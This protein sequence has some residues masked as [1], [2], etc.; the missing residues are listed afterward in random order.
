MYSKIEI[1]GEMELVTGMHIGGSDA[2]AAIGAIDSPVIKDVRT[3][4]PIVPGSSLKGK[5]RTLIARKIND[6]I[7]N[8]DDDDARIKR[9]FGCAKKGQVQ[10]SRL[11]FSDLTMENAEELRSQ[12]LTSMT[13]VKFENTINR[14][15][16]VAN[17][18][19]IEGA[20]RG[21]IFNFSVIYEVKNTEEIVD[22]IA[23]FTDGLKLLTYDYLGGNGSRGYG[24]VKFDNLDLECVIG[25]VDDE[26]IEECR[27]YI[28]EV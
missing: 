26:I 7:C 6:K 16:G 25:E 24:K 5:L 17:P 14:C 3:N 21:T 22:D 20:I 2:F 19:Q 28:K 27:K 12:G 23:L 13:E 4:L 15:T 1:S 10:R 18:R 11:I 8:P 9:L